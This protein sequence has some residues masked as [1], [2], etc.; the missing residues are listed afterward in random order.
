MHRE[1][2]H[3]DEAFQRE[4]NLSLYLFTGLVGILIGVDLWPALVSWSGLELPTWP[5]EIQGWRLVLVAAVLGGARVLYT[6]LESLLDGRLG[7]DLA[8][9]IATIAAI[10]FNKPLVAA[11]IVFI[12]L[13]GECLE[14]FT[15]ER[16]KRAIRQIAEI[17]PRRCWLLRDGKEVRVLVSELR[18]GDRVVVKPGARVPVDGIVIEGTSSLDTSALTGESLPNDVEPGSRVLA[19]SVNQFG[20]LIIDAERVGNQTVAG[21][22][23]QLTAQA[24]KDKA[25][26]ERTADRL[27]RW[28]LPVVLGLALATFL[29]ST[30]MNVGG[31]T[32]QTFAQ[33]ARLA[34]DPTL[35]VLVVA[36]PC[37]LILATPAALLAA[38]G[39]LAGT[40]VLVKSGAA[41][42]RLARVSAFAFDKTGTLTEGHLELGD[43]V[44]I[45]GTSR[46]EVIRLAATAEQRS[47]HPLARLLL[48]EA[49]LRRLDLEPIDEF[50][51]H[52]GAGVSATL[53][54]SGDPL[55]VGTR[56]L[57]AERGI[58]ASEEVEAALHRCDATGQTCLVVARAGQIVGVV[59]ARDRVRPEASTVLD[60]LRA[61]GIDHLAL[62]TGDRPAAARHVAET[63][64]IATVRAELL[65]HDKA[66]FLA[67][68]S[69]EV[70]KGKIAMVGDGLNDAPALARADVGLALGRTGT[71]LAAEA[72]DVVLMGDPLTPLPLLVQLAR[73]TLRVIHQNIVV[74]AFAVN[75]VGI[76]F[77]AWLWPFLA[78]TDWH[79]S[80]PLAA[81]LYHQFGSLAVLLN[82][83]RLLWFERPLARRL[84]SALDAVEEFLRRLDPHEG[85]HWL[86]NRWRAVVS[87]TALA[88]LLGWLASSLLT[89]GPDETVIVQRFGKALDTD[90]GPGLHVRWP[91]PIETAVRIRPAQVRIVEIGFRSR[92]TAAAS[93]GW[94]SAH[95]D[96][97][98]PDEAVVITGDGNLVE[99]QAVVRYSIL[100]PRRY[101]FAASQPE[102]IVRRA[103]EACLREAAAGLAFADLLTTHRHILEHQVLVALDRRCQDLGLGVRVEGLALP[104]LHPPQRVVPAYH[105]VSKA[106]EMRDR[107]VNEAQAEALRRIR[108]AESQAL[109]LIRQ[110]EA[111][112]HQRIA[113]AEAERAAFAGRIQARRQLSLRDEIRL[114]SDALGTALD[115]VS[116]ETVVATYRQ[117]RQ[118]AL[119]ARRLLTDFRLYWNAIGQGLGGRDKILI[120]ADKVPGRKHLM[121]LDPDLLRTPTPLLS[122]RFDRRGDGHDN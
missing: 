111:D 6:S 7:A 117:Q 63:L 87:A 113:R 98:L 76:I 109:A 49:A 90:F 89:V 105:D 122:P 42:E 104:D 85:I 20:A 33:A 74:F 2:T 119:V 79:E 115:G 72:G 60:Q 12:G 75:A 17:F 14:S 16:T 53:V 39:R 4:S 54:S 35:A 71:D 68:W 118:A 46:D 81:V 23:I 18:V 1:I 38:L 41:L 61:L 83:M 120:D 58:E 30:W 112:R 10:L 52:P 24:L 5:R 94:A 78:P 15:F 91:W 102:E 45:G 21:Q 107:L 34:L 116:A 48:D 9:A 22:L 32:Q 50:Q 88:I 106:M 8:L 70:G 64:Q 55:I 19:G 103:A 77:T 11:E 100:D 97:L 67:D 66:A 101:L 96:N 28:F 29:V 51:A 44:G 114:L 84:R 40:G 65:P 82:S 56:R 99:V 121:I 108:A 25:P 31:G 92:S 36:C 62:L 3:A 69:V 13:V 57:M 95:R 86:E 37:A 26:I 73:Q 47:E 80:A 59:A 93:A 43:V 110:A 27:A